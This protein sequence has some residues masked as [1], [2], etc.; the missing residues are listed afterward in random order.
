MEALKIAYEYVVYKIGTNYLED[1]TAQMIR[2]YLYKAIKGEMKE[3][4][5]DCPNVCMAP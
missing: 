4:C 3:V 5:L 1:A 2:D